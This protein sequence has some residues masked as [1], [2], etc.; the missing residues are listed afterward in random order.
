MSNLITVTL[1]LID[2]AYVHI[3][4]G[5]LIWKGPLAERGPWLKGGSSEPKSSSKNERAKMN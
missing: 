3:L 4:K 5:A 1:K 2:K